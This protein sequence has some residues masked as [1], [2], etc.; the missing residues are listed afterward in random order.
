MGP[1]NRLIAAIDRKNEKLRVQRVELPPVIT[2]AHKKAFEEVL[3]NKDYCIQETEFETVYGKETVERD[4]AESDRLEQEVFAR[5]TEIER[6]SKIIAETFEAIILMQAEMSN[7]LGEDVQTLKTARFDDYH[8]KVDMLAEWSNADGTRVL[9]LAV[10]VT[11]GLKTAARKLA[12]IR[13]EIDSGKLGSVRYFKDSRG[14]FMGTRNNAPRTIIGVSQERVAELAQLWLNKKQKELSAHPVQAL[15]LDEIERQLSLMRDYAARAGKADIV[16]A[17][18]QVLATVRPLKAEKECF[19]NSA[20]M[21]DPV[22]VNILE[23]ARA[24]LTHKF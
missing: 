12:A 21:E 11:F 14:D 4:I 15:F 5:Q 1:E 9:A 3:S 24:I 22:A 18:E 8:N 16:L 17:Y 23:E 6:N 20:F 19:A 13:E 10:D 2:R 7:W